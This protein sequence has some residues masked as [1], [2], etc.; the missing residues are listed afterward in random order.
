MIWLRPG[1]DLLPE[2]QRM[3]K[4]LT[5]NLSPEL[6]LKRTARGPWPAVF[7]GS[8]LSCQLT[9]GRLEGASNLEVVDP[10]IRVLHRCFLGRTHIETCEQSS[11]EFPLNT[12]E[13]SS[14]RLN[15]IGWSDFSSKEIPE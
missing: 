5:E 8:L 2:S 14:S 4:I 9:V 7:F 10:P 15:R 3:Y 1:Q 13:A 11:L 6:L 12:R